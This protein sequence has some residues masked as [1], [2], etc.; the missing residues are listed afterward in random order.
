[1]FAEYPDIMSVNESCEALRI[2]ANAMYELLHT[3]KVKGYRNGRTWRIPKQ[4]VI[5]YICTHTNLKK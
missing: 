2:G 5:E 1:M 4:A 3:G